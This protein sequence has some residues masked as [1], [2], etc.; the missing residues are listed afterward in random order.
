MSNWWDEGSANEI[1]KILEPISG[2]LNKYN[3]DTKIFIYFLCGNLYGENSV[4]YVGMTNNLASRLAGHRGKVY[5][6]V[7]FFSVSASIAPRVERA[8]IRAL[9][10]RFNVTSKSGYLTTDQHELLQDI[11]FADNDFQNI[12]QCKKLKAV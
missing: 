6:E 7:Y 4:L 10:P 12:L 1:P 8:L 2:Y 9:K 5:D 11:G 3:D